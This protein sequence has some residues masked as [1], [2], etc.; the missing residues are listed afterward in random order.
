M[1]NLN[2]EIQR[3]AKLDSN[4]HKGEKILNEWIDE[5]GIIDKSSIYY[6]DMHRLMVK[7]INSVMEE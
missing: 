7:I 3:Q 1:V 4:I 2:G 5:T 6:Y